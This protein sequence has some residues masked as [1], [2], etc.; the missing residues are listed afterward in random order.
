MT[1][2]VRQSG[3]TPAEEAT[4]EQVEDYGQPVAVELPEERATKFRTQGLSRI[5]TD[6]QP[7]DQVVVQRV[8][9]LTEQRLGEE[10]ADLYGVLYELYDIV[11]EKKTDPHTGAVIR[12]NDG[13]PEWRV[14]RNGNYIENW[15][16]LSKKQVSNF[17][18]TI[19]TSL[20]MWS[21]RAANIWLESMVAKTDWEI[22]FSEGFESIKPIS[23][24]KPTVQDR[25]ARGKL[26]SKEEKYFALY[27]TYYSKRAE[28]LV[29][30][31]E[32]LG[33]RL[34]DVHAP[35]GGR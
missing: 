4:E 27:Q 30:Y 34:K 14:R 8:Q 21:Q 5:R 28:A 32:L 13:L 15:E 17:L 33:Q 19:T 2:S 24:T 16:N 22:A 6:W 31:M 10:F 7:E 3:K 23:A 12:D 26:D 35:N 11:R 29:R 1:A 18:F 9:T 20:I 25:E